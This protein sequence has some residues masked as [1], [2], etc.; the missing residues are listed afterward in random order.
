MDARTRDAI[1]AR[2]RAVSKVSHTTWRI[3][4]V[5]A[6]GAVAIGAGFAHVLPNHL[7]HLNLGGTS[8]S[9][10]SSGGSNSSG[11]NGSSNSGNSGGVQS[12]NTVPQQGSG[13]GSHVTSGGS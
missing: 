3:G 5:A 13:N 6:I 9:S 2:D 12:P 7:P 8:G 10:G 1:A 11:D 4:G